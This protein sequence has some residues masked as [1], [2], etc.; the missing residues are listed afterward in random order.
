MTLYE[1]FVEQ[2]GDVSNP[3]IWVFLAFSTLW[4]VSDFL[5]VFFTAIFSGFKK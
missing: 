2:I 3:V 5:H 4:I 1:F